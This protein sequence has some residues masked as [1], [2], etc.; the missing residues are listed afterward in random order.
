MI[1]FH[2]K[3]A[4]VARQE[5]EQ[6]Y[7]QG[8]ALMSEHKGKVIIPIVGHYR[9]LGGF[10]TRSGSRIPELRVRTVG[11]LSKLKPLRRILVH[12]GLQK[13]QRSRLI[14]SLGLSVFTLHAA[15]FLL[16]PKVN[17][18]FGKRVFTK[19]T[20]PFMKERQMVRCGTPLCIS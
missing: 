8:W 5:A 10:I 17:I 20:N 13:E 9:H 3:G 15:H 1:S 12:E 16:L 7:G 2:G 11:A 18:K 4:T 6:K 19:S 14:K